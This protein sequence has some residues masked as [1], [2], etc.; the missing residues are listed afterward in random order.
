MRQFSVPQFIEV[1]DKIFGPL[2][3][4]QFIYLLGGVATVFIIYVF[5]PFFLTV[6]LGLPVAG[7]ALALAF[8]KVHNQPFINVMANAVSYYTKSKLY[9]WKRSETKKPK[10]QKISAP[11]QEFVLPKTT[12]SKLKDLAWSLD[13]KEKIK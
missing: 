5:L 9:I 11:K 10:A 7:L 12:E 2:T 4:K 3:L 6:L 1:E 8:Y 13:V